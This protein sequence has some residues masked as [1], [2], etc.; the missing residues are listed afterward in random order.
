M[1]NRSPFGNLTAAL[2]VVAVLDLVIDR[3]MGRLFVAP[4]CRTGWGCLWLG[5]GPFL[6]HLTGALALIVAAGGIAGHLKR[7]ELFPKGMRLTIAALSMVFLLLL[8]LS[9]VVGRVPE[10]YHVHL[11]TSYGF[12]VVLLAMSFVGSKAASTRTRAGFVLFVLP[13]LLHMGALVA[14]RAGWMRN[15]S[16]RPEHL[17]LA[18]ELALLLAAL[19]APL[20]LVPR[21]VPHAFISTGLALA[22]GVSAFF[23]VAYLGRTDLVQ[24][25]AL[26]SVHLE[27]PRAMSPLGALY[28]LALFGFVTAL[29]ILLLSPGAPRLA[30]LGMCLIGVGGYQSASPVALAISLCGFLALA[31]GT[32]RAGHE[33]ASKGA[34]LSDAAW[35]ALLGAIAAGI[36]ESPGSGVQP[37]LIEVLGA[38]EGGSDGESD[39]GGVRGPRRGKPIAL[40]IRRVRGVIR[41]LD[42]KVG[43]L[44]DT[45]P[46][47]TIESH[48]A[49]LG[50]PPE[51]RTELPRTKTGDP[52]FDRKLGVYGR[53]A[54][55]ERALR[56]RILRL[57]DGT[58]TLWHGRAARFALSGNP[59]ESLR[60]F[61]LQ[62]PA[63]TARSLVDLVDL[64]LD[65]VEANDGSRPQ[66]PV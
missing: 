35:R 52:T 30:G 10:R 37:V 49:W 47:A 5:T 22:A 11:E 6:L 33:G 36:A 57:A 60:R 41:G 3:L 14:A 40:T 43:L 9:L 24:T 50:R 12:V 27:L 34:R 63:T 56:R 29:V 31:T 53:A 32:L 61:S 7:G 28:V 21:G 44:G 54:L 18:G 26:Y 62:T 16:V 15:Q 51:D 19:S 13:A 20:L 2:V 55:G 17:T 39:V 38:G 45:P 64:L 65:L 59:S 25:V 46:D 42:V 4:G 1:P 23:F 8:A 58:I 66:E 48:E